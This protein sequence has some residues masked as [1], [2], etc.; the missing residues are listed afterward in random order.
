MCSCVYVY[1]YKS[2]REEEQDACRVWFRCITMVR[3]LVL[4]VAI[5]TFPLHLNTYM[6]CTSMHTYMYVVH[7]G[8]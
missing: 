2:T 1:M 6:L 7:V 3:F 8:R 5:P 4:S